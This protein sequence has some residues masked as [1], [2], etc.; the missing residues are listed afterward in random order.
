MLGT[1][2]VLQWYRAIQHTRMG[3]LRNF[4]ETVVDERTVC[5]HGLAGHRSG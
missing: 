2:P 4:L 5:I 3:A 1:L